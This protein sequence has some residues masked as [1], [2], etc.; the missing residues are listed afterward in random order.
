MY[1]FKRGFFIPVRSFF[2]I[3]LTL[4]SVRLKSMQELSGTVLCC[5]NKIRGGG[6]AIRG[7][8]WPS[9]EVDR[10]IRVPSVSAHSTKPAEQRPHLFTLSLGVRGHTDISIPRS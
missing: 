5:K 2:F 7:F 1:N 9:V 10:I 3:V 8:S 4:T 6:E